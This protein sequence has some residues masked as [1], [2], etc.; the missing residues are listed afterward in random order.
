LKPER[1]FEEVLRRAAR[2]ALDLELPTVPLSYPPNAALGDLATPI[3]FEL[4]RSL[5]KAPRVLAEAI[6]EAFEPGGGIARVEVAGG[7]YLN[8]FLDRDDSL[9]C[10]LAGERAAVPSQEPGKIIVE[11]TNINPNKAA[12]I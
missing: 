3:C 2:R 6:A 4:A 1:A 12:H 7:G 8:G 5:R 9:R 10:W 11:H